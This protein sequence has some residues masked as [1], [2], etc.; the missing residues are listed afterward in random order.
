MIHK[1]NTRRSVWLVLG[2]LGTIISLS[3]FM[4]Q[5][6]TAQ[7]DDRDYRILWLVRPAIDALYDLYQLDLEGHFE[8]VPLPAFPELENRFDLTDAQLSP[9][10]N[11]LALSI[12]GTPDNMGTNEAIYLLDF[13]NNSLQ[14]LTP[15]PVE[16]NNWHAR[17]SPDGH[18]LA[19][20]VGRFS[21][22]IQILDL[23]TGQQRAIS[24][25]KDSGEYMGSPIGGFDWSPTGQE[26]VIGVVDRDPGE[27]I[28]EYSR[29]VTHNIP[30]N[31]TRILL[32]DYGTKPVWTNAFPEVIY[33]CSRGMF[34]EV[35]SLNL[36]TNEILQ[37]SNFAITF[38]SVQSDYM[39]LDMDVNAEGH[40]IVRLIETDTSRTQYESLYYND[41][42]GFR[43]LY[44]FPSDIVAG[45]PQW[46]SASIVPD[47]E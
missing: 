8:R 5:I 34:L 26:L 4:Q 3:S 29:I 14:K 13:P 24:L 12:I 45:S 35:C 11:R 37:L 31:L 22:Q 15:D 6:T 40:I 18:T 43:Q 27:E 42:D 21:R 10:G 23:R 16:T 33:F 36:D 46:I 44:R 2:W 28:I 38:R 41:G 39:L 30:D 19:F 32:G 17:W 25:T 7:S 20:F 1:L 9:D 47:T